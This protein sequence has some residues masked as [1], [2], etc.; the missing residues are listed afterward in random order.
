MNLIEK[1]RKEFKNDVMTFVINHCRDR[2]KEVKE[3]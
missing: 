2:K 1:T 3:K